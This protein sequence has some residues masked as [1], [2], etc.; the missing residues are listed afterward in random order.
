MVGSD[1]LAHGSTGGEADVEV[2]LA[3]DLFGDQVRVVGGR[4]FDRVT[5]HAPTAGHHPQGVC[6]LDQ[7]SKRTAHPLAS[8]CRGCIAAGDRYV[9]RA[10]PETPT[11]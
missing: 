3:F 8:C 10:T 1:T 2:D 7:G 11:R 5:L 9:P 4:V 6:V